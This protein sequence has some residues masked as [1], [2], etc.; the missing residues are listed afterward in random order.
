MHDLLNFH[1]F[2]ECVFCFIAFVMS[3]SRVRFISPDFVYISY[4]QLL[5][6]ARFS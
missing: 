4:D 6:C 3:A 2:P 1:M 5:T